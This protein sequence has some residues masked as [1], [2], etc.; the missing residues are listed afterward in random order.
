LKTDNTGVI[1]NEIPGHSKHT[2]IYCVQEIRKCIY[3]SSGIIIKYTGVI[4]NA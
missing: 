1:K 3:H 2:H 4:I